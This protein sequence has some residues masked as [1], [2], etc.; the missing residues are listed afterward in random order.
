MVAAWPRPPV[1]WQDPDTE[2]QFQT[3][4]EIV[5][6]IREIRS[7]QN[8]PLVKPSMSLFCSEKTAVAHTIDTS[9]EAMQCA[10]LF[11]VH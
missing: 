3:F 11:H 9:I 5:A 10:V 2:S 6:A 7:R 8:I 1:S 4:L